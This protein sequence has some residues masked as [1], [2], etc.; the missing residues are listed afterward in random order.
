MYR[1]GVAVLL[2]LL[3][4]AASNRRIGREVN[5][6]SP[7]EPLELTHMR[8]QAEELRQQGSFPEAA[9]LFQV[10]WHQAATENAWHSAVQSLNSLGAVRQ[11]MFQYQEALNAYLEA[12][13]IAEPWGYSTQVGLIYA[14]LA[15]AYFQLG[16]LNSSQLAA[17][18]GLRQS[19]AHEDIEYKSQLLTHLALLSA[20]RQQLPKAFQYFSE[21]IQ[22]ADLAGNT[23]VLVTAWDSLGEVSLQAD[24]LSQAE[25]AFTEAY[26]LRLL[27]HGTELR[28]SYLELSRLRLVQGDLHSAAVLIDRARG[29]RGKVAGASLWRELDQ[30]GKVRLA[31]GK[32]DSAVHAFRQAWTATEE[33]R[34]EMAPADLSGNASAVEIHGIHRSFVEASLALHPPSVAE[35]FLAVEDDRA[36]TMRREMAASK[37]W[38]DH[39]PPQYWDTLRRLREVQTKLVAHESAV[40]EAEARR[41][42]HL[43]TQLEIQAGLSAPTALGVTADQNSSLENALQSIQ[44]RLAPQEALLSF[45]LGEERCYLWAVTA[46]SLEV[47]RLPN[48][49]QLITLA[50]QFRAAVEHSLASRDELGWETYQDLFGELS[51]HVDGKSQWL[52]TADDALFDLPFAPLV[53]QKR[54]GTSTY[55][56][57]KHSTERIPSALMAPQ[58]ESASNRVFVG[59]G[60]GI[61][62]TA[63]PR[64]ISLKRDNDPELGDNPLQLARIPASGEELTASADEWQGRHPVLLSGWNANRKEFEGALNRHPQ[65]VHIAA[66]F[67][68]PKNKPERTLIDLGISA[69]GEPEVLTQEDISNFR[70][71]GATVV[72]SGCSSAAVQ[73]LPGTGVLGLTRAWLVAGASAVIGSRWPTPDD[74]GELFQ[75]FY[76]DLRIRCDRGADGRVGAS[77][78]HAQLEMLRSNTWRSNPSYWSAFYAVGKEQ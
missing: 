20:R 9:S 61:Y 50:K 13:R 33:W 54:E 26:R 12:Q 51:A 46:N 15:S 71:P 66:H 60:D 55:L 68:Q 34:D 2:V 23:S 18:A 40:T 63:D 27:F 78:Q 19:A 62:N 65:I 21:A 52:I 14:N 49:K 64:W 4:F 43:M 39:L 16:D 28:Q 6:K 11:A 41:L 36:D 77:L 8:A 47:H 35:A 10:A 29:M 57:E 24:L 75:S 30:L 1:F 42:R 38:R 32:T 70:V 7:D 48:A 17:E 53:V 44:R 31:E 58:P 37:T 22:A 59:I 56:V 76:R 3:I 69:S 45:Y 72:M 73:P 74:T 25:R 67:L 5:P